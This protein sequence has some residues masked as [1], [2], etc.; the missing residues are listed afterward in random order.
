MVN[1]GLTGRYLG[2]A[3]VLDIYDFESSYSGFFANLDHQERT[4]SLLI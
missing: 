3:K 2:S 4:I 1:E